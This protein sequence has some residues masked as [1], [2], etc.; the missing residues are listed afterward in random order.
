[1]GQL[2][3]CYQEE[4]WH[5]I[6]KYLQVNAWHLPTSWLLTKAKDTM[7]HRILVPICSSHYAEKWFPVVVE[8]LAQSPTSR[9]ATKETPSTKATNDTAPWRVPETY[10]S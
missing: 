7:M 8:T 1:M 3:A 10:V 4:L 5:D 6:P 9:V 2:F